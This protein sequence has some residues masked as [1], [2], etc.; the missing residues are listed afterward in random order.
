MQNHYT[1]EDLV[2]PIPP[3]QEALTM[4]LIMDLTMAHIII[5]ITILGTILGTIQD[6]I[7]DTILPIALIYI[8]PTLIHFNPKQ[9]IDYLL[10]K[11]E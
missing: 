2:D 9:M 3:I 6:T 1:V 7:Q 5:R 11:E 8:H 10:M 4:V